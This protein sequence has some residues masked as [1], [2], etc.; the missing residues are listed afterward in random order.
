MKLKDL[1][2]EFVGA[3]GPGITNADGSTPER[4]SGVGVIMDC[5]CG[6]CDEHRRLFVPFRNPIDGG[7]PMKYGALWERTGDTIESLTLSPSVN[8]L[9]GCRWH[10][11]IRNGEAVECGS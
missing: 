3:G 7:P 10:G 2:A 6:E 1:N 8:R 5:P 4:R 9:D 11:W